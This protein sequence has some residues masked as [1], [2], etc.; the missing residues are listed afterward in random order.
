MISLRRPGETRNLGMG[1][2]EK[3][4]AEPFL[5]RPRRR[6]DFAIGSTKARAERGRANGS[7]LVAA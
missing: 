5:P 2:Q 4:S 6:W 1:P 3:G 7:P